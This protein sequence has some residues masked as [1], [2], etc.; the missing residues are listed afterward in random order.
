MM[1]KSDLSHVIEIARSG[2]PFTNNYQQMEG[3]KIC[4]EDGELW[5]SF[6]KCE[7]EMIVTKNGRRMF[8]VIRVRIAG[9]D[10]NAMYSVILDF[11]PADKKRWKYVNGKWEP[12]GEKQAQHTPCLP[13]LHPDSPN[14]G[15]H[16]MKD[17]IAFSK[18]K[19]SNKCSD[20]GQ[21][22]L[23][24]LHKYQP[25]IHIVRLNSD[26]TPI[27]THEFTDTQFVAV[28]AY[29]NEQV[30]ALKIRHNPFA[31]AF[32]DS[33][34]KQGESL[35]RERLFDQA[36]LSPAHLAQLNSSQWC[37]QSMYP[38]SELSRMSGCDT[39]SRLKSHRSVPYS[40]GY[41]K[42][43]SNSAPCGDNTSTD[44]EFKMSPPSEDPFKSSLMS[45]MMP[46]AYHPCSSGGASSSLTPYC[47]PPN[48]ASS[49]TSGFFP[50][51]SHCNGAQG[52]V[53]LSFSQYLPTTSV[54][55]SAFPPPSS[56]SIGCNFAET[57]PVL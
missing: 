11:I 38:G 30:T 45:A 47:W 16:W 54:G 3:V 51:P 44:Y 15:A 7:N 42:T 26:V 8:P 43:Q 27:S 22:L 32:L 39:Y 6:K 35:K 31:K 55:A 19:L 4:L 1:I 56:N 49:D 33:K 24:S 41:R 12:S 17:A 37:L 34:D 28:T 5:R 57:K 23:N 53:S 14:F 21:V 2:I 48:A 52:D 40:I 25:R 18:V 46:A 29:Q 10:P 20:K 36:S 9:L 50:P 13:Y